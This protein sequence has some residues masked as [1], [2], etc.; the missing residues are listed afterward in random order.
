[1]GKLLNLRVPRIP[2]SHA[3]SQGLDL[4]FFPGEEMPAFGGSSSPISTE[5][6]LFAGNSVFGL[7][8]RIKAHGNNV[9]IPPNVKARNAVECSSQA[10]QHLGAKHWTLVVNQRKNHRL[11]A[12]VLA[13]LNGLAALIRKSQVQGHLGIESLLDAYLIE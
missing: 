6:A 8:T 3:R 5:K 12:K 10:V 4:V 13:E 2:K 1:M 9:K 11:G 7:V